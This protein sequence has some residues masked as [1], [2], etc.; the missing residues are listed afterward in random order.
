MFKLQLHE[1]SILPGWHAS[2]LY[3]HTSLALFASFKRLLL[4]LALFPTFA[5]LLGVPASLAIL[6]LM[7]GLLNN[8]ANASMVL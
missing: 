8:F 7:A 2:F 4:M 6:L 1:R 3:E 5:C